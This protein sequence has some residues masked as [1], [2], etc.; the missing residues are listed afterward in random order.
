MGIGTSWSGRTFGWDSSA[1]MKFTTETQHLGVGQGI[2]VVRDYGDFAGIYRLG[3]QILSSA[4][5]TS[6]SSG[7]GRTARRRSGSF[8]GRAR[9]KSAR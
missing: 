2:F 4:S 5:T 1:R 9:S 7:P 3:G 8:I 6:S